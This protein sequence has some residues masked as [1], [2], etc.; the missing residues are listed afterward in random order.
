MFVLIFSGCNDSSRFP[1]AKASGVVICEGQPVAHVDLRFSP[2]RTGNSAISGARAMATTDENGKFVLSTYDSTKKD[3]AIIGK[4]EV[5][6]WATPETR[7]DTPAALSTSEVVTE[8]EVMKGKKNE[9]TIELR[10]RAPREVLVIP[11]ESY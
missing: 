3:G 2:V 1:L 6:V 10:K 9:F 11:D 8:V 5:Y 4:H 7:S